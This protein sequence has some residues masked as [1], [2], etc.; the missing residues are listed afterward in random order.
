MANSDRQLT[1]LV[2]AI[3][4]GDVERTA[5]MITAS[6]GLAKAC[7]QT[8]ASRASERPHFLTQIS[9]YIYAG[10]TALHIAAAAYESKI[11]EELIKA[12]ADVRATNRFGYNPLH[13]A[14][15]GNPMSR[16]WNPARQAA[17]IRVLIKSGAD[18]N[19]TDKR[20]VT[21]LHIAVRTRCA[22]A[23]QTL[24]E[25]GADRSRKNKSGSDAMLLAVYTTGRGDSGSPEAKR[26]QQQI[27]QLIGGPGKRRAASHRVR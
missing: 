4:E 7:F 10:D 5:E 6:R 1:V 26:E 8:G 18:P 25:C 9:R 13:S 17:T 2:K 15:A 16:Y 21:P 11:A 23:V 12:G 24:L 14:A 20:G 22:L 19:S 3:L 27:V